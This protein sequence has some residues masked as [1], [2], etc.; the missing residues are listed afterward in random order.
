MN[1]NLILTHKDF[2]LPFSLG[3]LGFNDFKVIRCEKSTFVENKYYAEISG[4]MQFY[5]DN[6]DKIEN[7]D[8]ISACSYR[9]YHFMVNED[10]FVNS[11][12][13]EDF[14]E[15]N[16]IVVNTKEC[17]YKEH[18]YTALEL[19]GI[20]EG[21]QNGLNDGGRSIDLIQCRDVIRDEYPDMMTAVDKVLMSTDGLHYRNMFAMKGNLFKEY[22]KFLIN[23]LL[24]FEEEHLDR[25]S[26]YPKSAIRVM[27]YLAEYLLNFFIE[28][29]QLN[30]KELDFYNTE[31]KQIN[32]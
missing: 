32:L 5:S 20:N 10:R 13:Y 16:D 25:I 22:M 14:L 2:L 28:Y 29:K 23:V 1:Y 3:T 12:D 11:F 4:L 7:D 9:R 17:L 6:K 15:K 24:T 19:Y 27:G 26:T 8:I 18:P 31:W 21:N 30:K